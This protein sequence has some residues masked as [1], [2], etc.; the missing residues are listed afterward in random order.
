MDYI[1]DDS[2][3][4]VEGVMLNRSITEQIMSGFS[5]Q[6]AGESAGQDTD[7]D[8]E[9]MAREFYR[10]LTDEALEQSYQREQLQQYQSLSENSSPT[11]SRSRRIA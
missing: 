2:F 4:G 11:D 7:A 3:R 6:T 10:T 1:V 9:R 8:R 5:G